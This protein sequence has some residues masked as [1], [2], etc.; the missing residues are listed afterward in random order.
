MNRKTLIS[1]VVFVGLG[2][3]AFLALRSPEKGERRGPK[4]GPSGIAKINKDQVDELEVTN[5][6]KKTALKKEGDKWW[7]TAPVRYP[8]DFD[9]GV[10]NALEKLAD[11]SWGD[12]VSEQ[13]GKQ[14]EM[15][16]DDEKGVH[17]VVKQGGKVLADIIVG[18]PVGGYTM[19]RPAGSDQIW[20]AGG[21]QKWALAKDT[22]DWR[23]KLITD[24][25]RDD[26]ETVSVETA[27]KGKVTVKRI[28]PDK[29]KKT[30]EKFEVAEAQGAKIDKLDDSVA[31]GLVN[32]V[33]NIRAFDFADGA[34]AA[35]TGL[36][37]PEYVVTTKAAGKT[38]V[39][40]IGKNKGEN[41]YAKTPEN[42]QVFLIPKYTAERFT[43][44]P[45][46]FRDKL[47]TDIKP[48]DVAGLEITQGGTTVELE[49]NGADWKAKKPAGMI[50][51]PVK[52]GPL[53]QGFANWRAA[54]FGDAKAFGKQTAKIVVRTK[55]KKTTTI[56]IGATKE[57]DVWVQVSGRPDTYVVKKYMVDRFLKKPDDLKKSDAT[58]KKS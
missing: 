25:K 15:E 39:V 19:V 41:F 16:V 37:K 35:E 46:D 56:V 4:S 3:G 14:K 49:K 48:D 27:G 13:K 9:A 20:Q 1:L 21:L 54:S 57:Q 52:V 58:A 11:L 51:D 8:A 2:V 17:V 7:V 22:K 12:V 6:G 29:D 10:K 28:A 31:Q 47:I 42:P 50:A 18:K 38:Y 34:A 24:F 53:A 43:K 44:P 55:D 33:Y 40:Q 45:V 32:T 26:I 30:S 23:L 36:D 5:A